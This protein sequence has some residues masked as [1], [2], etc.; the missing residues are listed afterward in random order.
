M[1]RAAVPTFTLHL[2]TAAPVAVLEA[3]LADAAPRDQAV[4]ASGIEPPR[5]APGFVLARRWA[6][7]GL[8]H[9]KT[10]RDGKDRR[11]TRWIV[12]RAGTGVPSDAADLCDEQALRVSATVRERADALLAILQDCAAARR[13]CP[14]LTDLA[15]RLQL[16]RRQRGRDKVRHAL[17]LLAAER[18]IEVRTIGPRGRTRRVVKVLCEGKAQ[19]KTTKRPVGVM[20]NG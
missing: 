19:G 4:Y 15:E 10:E 5:D 12:E 17:A 1:T 20:G 9:L 18:K 3:W 2:A 7:Q 8:V 6:E 11:L 16:G 13:E 14:S